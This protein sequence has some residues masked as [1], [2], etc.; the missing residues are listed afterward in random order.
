MGSRMSRTGLPNRRQVSETTR[1]DWHLV[2]CEFPPVMGGVADFTGAVAAALSAAGESVHVWAPRPAGVGGAATVHEI[3][4]AYRVT[5]LRALDRALDACRRPRRLFVQ[6]VPHGYGYKSLNVPFCLWVRHRARRGDSLDLM[7]HE[8]FLPFDRTR[9]RQN[10]GA[11]VHRAMLAILLS[12]ADR[13]WVSTP[14]FLPEVRR[15]GPRRG[16]EYAWLPIP[17]PVTPVAEGEARALARELGSGVVGYFGTA[18]RLVARCLG[19]TMEQVASRRP[20]VRFALVGAGTDGFARELAGSRPAVAS[21]ILTAGP[22]SAV[23]VSRL[24][25]CCD[26]FLQPYPD[27]VSTRRTTMMAL[28]QHGRAV[29]T[30]AGPRTE[31]L[32]SR[33]DAVR[34]VESAGPAALAE[35][36]VDLIA[37]PAG[38]GRLADRARMLYDSTF[39]LAH[40]RAALMGASPRG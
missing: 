18:N 38:R 14:S 25:Q 19:D 36:V 27:G 20:D 21:S 30:N 40:V 10:V 24:I 11:L 1:A 33:S 3:A 9:V 12:A 23:D 31:P 7:V 29:V 26:L 15:F 37:D 8:P 17:S 6:W 35:A 4:G 22:R 13:V 34:L 28:L 5:S 16:V 39:A 32:W 2:T